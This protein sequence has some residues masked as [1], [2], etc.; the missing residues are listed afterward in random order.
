MPQP[1]PF[2]SIAFGNPSARDHLMM[3]KENYLDKLIPEMKRWTPPPNSS[4]VT[5]NELKRLQQYLTTKREV[6]DNMYDEGLLDMI[7]SHFIKAGADKEFVTVVTEGVAEDVIPLITKLK[8]WF[9]RPR[10]S[11]LS[12]YY[13]MNFFPDFSYFVNNPSYPSGHSTLTAVTCHVLGNLYPEA[14]KTIQGVIKEARES[15]L[16]LGL[17]YPSDNDMA[18][19]VAKN[20]LENPEFKANYRL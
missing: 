16:Y 3:T 13:D 8:Y 17:H 6:K 1:I 7:K 15:R 20:V 5:Q 9:N 12:W 2:D 10:P 11:Q 18:M 19:V 14:Y 4:S